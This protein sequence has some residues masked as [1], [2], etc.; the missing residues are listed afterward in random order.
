MCDRKGTKA[1]TKPCDP[2]AGT[3]LS[4]PACRCLYTRSLRACITQEKNICPVAQQA[5]ALHG[6]KDTLSLLSDAEGKQP[7]IYVGVNPS[8]GMRFQSLDS[9]QAAV[10]WHLMSC[11]LLCYRFKQGCRLH[12]E[13]FLANSFP[14]QPPHV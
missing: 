3:D 11:K 4:L 14:E 10:W 7:A 2:A 1:S 8:P 5:A 6:A 9:L 12:H 13:A